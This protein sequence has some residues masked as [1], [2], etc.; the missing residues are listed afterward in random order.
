ME[1]TFGKVWNFLWIFILCA[2]TPNIKGLKSG[3]GI[4]NYFGDL[5]WKAGEKYEGYWENDVKNGFGIYTYSQN[6][7]IQ[8]YEGY[9]AVRKLE[10]L[11]N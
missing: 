6:S 7:D 3:F 8:K 10:Q 1:F 2:N 11:I 5:N 4:I 9:Y